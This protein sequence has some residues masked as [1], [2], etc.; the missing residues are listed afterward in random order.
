MH[1]QYQHERQVRVI[2]NKYHQEALNAEHLQLARAGRP[3]PFSGLLISLV[4]TVT[5]LPGIVQARFS[6]VTIVSPEPVAESEP[7]SLQELVSKP[8]SAPI[9]V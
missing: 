7:V 1:T 9:T 3:N 5:A 2:I 8:I 6:H 4:S